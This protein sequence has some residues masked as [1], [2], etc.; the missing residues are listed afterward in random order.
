MTGRNGGHGAC[1]VPGNAF[2]SAR[3][4]SRPK[5]IRTVVDGML[6]RPDVETI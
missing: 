6:K 1:K 5:Q 4:D 2:T 3:Y